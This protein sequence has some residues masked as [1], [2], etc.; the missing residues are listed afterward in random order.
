[1]FKYAVKSLMQEKT[2]LILSIGGVAFALILILT[3][4]GIYA[5]ISRKI[6]IYIDTNKADVFVMQSGVKNMHMAR[7]FMPLSL[8]QKLEKIEGVE[9]VTGINYGNS[10]TKLHNKRLFSYL[11]GFDPNASVG[12]PVTVIKGST[13]PKEDGIILDE[14][15]VKKHGF[16]IGDRI[17]IIGKNFKLVGITRGT[18]SIASTITFLNRK[19]L[20]S[21]VPPGATSYFLIKTK[22]GY[23][24]KNVTR[25]IDDKIK[26]VNALTRQQFSEH[27]RKVAADM[28]AQIIDIMTIIGFISAILIVALTIY[29]ATLEKIGEFGVMKA[30]GASNGR[31]YR[32][33][34]QQTTISA[35]FGLIFG[36]AI[37]YIISWLVVRVSPEISMVIEPASL[38][39]AVIA[40]VFISALASYVPVR[41]IAK[42]DPLLVFKA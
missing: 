38:I 20:A 22:N 35:F 26:G 2:K 11:I 3:L 17:K 4:D 40:T 37:T 36:I 16:K 19:A 31:L 29:T 25:K 13:N 39:K 41:S 7:S 15:V 21:F 6:T 33:V 27:D 42:V 18:Y 14:V 34:I 5:G 24:S 12:G 30:I 1:M 23:S 8:Q 10:A 9:E 32:I 28:G